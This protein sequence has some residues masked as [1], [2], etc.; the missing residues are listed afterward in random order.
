ML[1]SK[2]LC[3]ARK[4]NGKFIILKFVHRRIRT[5]YRVAH[6]GSDNYFQDVILLTGNKIASMETTTFASK[7]A[8]LLD[9]MVAICVSTDVK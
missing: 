8:T 9:P 4:P 1:T 5:S 2:V 3:P 6:V 7:H